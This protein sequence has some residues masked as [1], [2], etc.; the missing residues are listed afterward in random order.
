MPVQW[1]GLVYAYQIQRLAKT[2][3][4]HRPEA[5]GSPL[6][7]SLDFTPRDWK[8]LAE[9]IAISAQYQQF[10]EGKL[11][12]TYPDSITDFI[13]RNPA[14]INPED[15]AVNVLALNGFDPDIKTVQVA[16]GKQRLVVSSGA[17]IVS[18]RSAQERL[19]LTLRYFAGELSH[20]LIA[21]AAEPKSIAC[22]GRPLPRSHEPLQRQAGWWWD[23]KTQRLFIAAPHQRM[24]VSLDVE[25]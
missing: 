5:N 23:G 12:G 21:N 16:V 2:L 18:T 15:I 20:T 8:R 1:C 10:D 19:S 9:L 4:R 13:H 11:K 25:W 24:A 14:F 7:L 22:D 3:E 6:P 17:D